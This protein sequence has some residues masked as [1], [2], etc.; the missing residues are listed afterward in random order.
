M[1]NTTIR[2]ETVCGYMTGAQAEKGNKRDDQR[3]VS[4]DENHFS[5][6]MGYFEVYQADQ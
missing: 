2:I 1:I 3:G 6:S 5:L 4:E